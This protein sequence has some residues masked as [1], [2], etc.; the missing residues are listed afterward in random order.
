MSQTSLSVSPDLGLDLGLGLVYLEKSQDGAVPVRVSARS[1][2]G[3][4]GDSGE[5]EMS[6][7]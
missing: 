7:R 6:M 3:D 2:Q 4:K 1:L 5:H